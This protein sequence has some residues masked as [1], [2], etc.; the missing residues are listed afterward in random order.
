MKKRFFAPF[1]ALAASGALILGGVAPANA[2]QPL[3]T[4]TYSVQAAKP[5][6]DNVTISK[7]KTVKANKKSKKATVKPVVKSSGKVKVTS[8]K[9]T[10]KQGKKTIVKNK[11]SASLKAGKYTVTTTAKYK[12]WSNKTTTKNVKTKKL[13]SDGTK[14]VKM[15]CKV[16]KIEPQYF[17]G[18]FIDLLHL[19]CTGDFDGTYTARAG[20]VWDIDENWPIAGDMIWGESF[21]EEPYIRSVLGLKFTT[22]VYPLEKNVYKTTVTKKSTTSK[23]WSKEKSKSLKQTLVVKK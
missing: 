11:D 2:A 6:P 5:T 19:E 16:A 23:I 10:V 21:P 22:T 15:N 8:K 14:P 17:E 4:S 7:I 3:A 9:I 1:V 13:V 12:T 18:F 20:Y